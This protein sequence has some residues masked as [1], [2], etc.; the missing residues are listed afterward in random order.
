MEPA[1]R[2]EALDHALRHLAQTTATVPRLAT[3]ALGPDRISLHLVDAAELPAPWAGSGT[4]WSMPIADIASEHD[5]EVPPYP[6]LVSLGQSTDGTLVFL[7]LE[8][9]GCAVV[10]GDEEKAAALGRHIAAELALNPW[11]SLV[12]IDTIGIGAELAEIDP[13]RHRHHDAC[14]T[15]FLDLLAT[16]LEAEDAHQ[17][18]DQYRAL[19][20]GP[21]AGVDL[22][23]VR[24]AGKIITAYPGRAGAA[25]VIVRGEPRP[26]DVEL[27]V[28]S[29]GRLRIARLGLD[30]IT[31][32]L[33]IDE[34]HACA[35]L[36]DLTREAPNV[37]VP[38]A[39]PASSMVMSGALDDRLTEPRPAD[40]PAGERSLLPAPVREYEASAATTA[41]DLHRLAPLAAE[42][43]REHLAELDPCLDEDLARWQS[44]TLLAPKL[45]LLGP[46][47]ARTQGDAR[48]IAHRRPFYTELLAFLVLHPGG[49]T[50]NDVADALG[51]QPE[52]ARKD[53]GIVRG[54]LGTDPRTGQ[55]YLPNARQTHA[56]GV[57]ATYSVNGVLTD[58][59]LFRRLR[60]RG[61]SRGA[62][63]IADLQ[64]AL[65]LVSGEPFTNLR[66]AGWAWLLDGDRIDHIMTC[67]IVDTAH[68]VTTHALHAGDLAMAR[69]SAETAYQSAPYDETSRLDLIAVAEAAGDDVTTTRE[70]IDGVLNRT[71]DD[72]GPIELP[73]RAQQVI[74]QRE[75]RSKTRPAR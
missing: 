19:I 70:L 28:T 68:I 56:T 10:T 54:W 26:N 49:V 35:A 55:L 48:Q 4:N 41:E 18:P 14:D 3:A 39:D 52:R 73:E 22:E 46:V 57:P 43:T 42:G 44:P 21:D 23:D 32:G 51:L 9:V 65:E 33:T 5:G 37:G 38:A 27:R 40:R 31:A 66:P 12:E 36:V 62:D 8:E 64:A 17:A 59:D 1:P 16:A 2:I 74:R 30:L 45:T 25:V 53:L 15:R 6:L 72:L 34:A 24:R 61:Q 50:A 75:W 11:S 7:N 63:G 67:T 47:S 69:F 58:L 20:V 13:V 71:D 60:A 29:A